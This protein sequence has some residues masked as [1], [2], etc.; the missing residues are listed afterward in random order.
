MRFL[1]LRIEEGNDEP[2]GVGK[3]AVISEAIDEN[4]R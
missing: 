4:E 2:V 1:I 3:G